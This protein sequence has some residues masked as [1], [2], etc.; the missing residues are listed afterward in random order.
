MTAPVRFALVGAGSIAQSYAQAFETCAAARLVAV[1]D[2]RA[3]AARA[4]AE[5]FCCPH[6]SSHHDLARE[7]ERFDAVVVCTPPNTHEDVSM[8]FVEQGRHVLCEKPFTLSTASA[9]RMLEA[10]Q[11]AGVL[12]TMASKFRYVDD[13]VHA[14]S[15]LASGV[16]GEVILWENA[17]TARVD[18][19]QRWNANPAISGG[20]VLIDNGTHSVDLMRCFLGP[21]AGVLAIEGKRIQELPVED[22]V[23][24]FV[25]S[26]C[27]VMGSIDL[28]WSFNKE[29]DSYVN[30]NGSH[31]TLSVGWKESRYRQ[32]SNSDWT[33]FGRG[34]SKLQA[35][36]S[37]IA[38]FAGAIRGEEELRITAEDALASVE[39]VEAAYRS[40]R[41]QH[42]T[43]VNKP[44]AA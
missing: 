22:T 21:V 30:I 27:G 9:R 33:V 28:S 41:Q 42:W 7:A 29:L 14:R 5:R 23:R 4:L 8:H 13:V 11:R 32:L 44:L 18:M 1:A 16:L 20:G 6:Y 35:F 36:R 26:T 19:T 39:V 3:E 10:S 2:V 17:F 40:L 34:Y 25:R 38:N 43:T 15:L 24:L 12:L 37:Q 31:G